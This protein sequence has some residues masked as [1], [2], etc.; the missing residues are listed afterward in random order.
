[1]GIE[2]GQ[3][4]EEMRAGKRILVVEDNLL[5]ADI[6]SFF[7]RDYG[8]EF[9][10]VDNGLTAVDMY[11]SS[12]YDLVLMDIML[13]GLNGY[14]ATQRIIENAGSGEKPLVI[15]VTAKV[16]RDNEQNSVM[17]GMVDLIHKPI[18]FNLLL[19]VLDKYLFGAET[20][21]PSI[22]PNRE[23][24]T[25]K[26]GIYDARMLNEYCIHVSESGA[27]REA[28]ISHFL[29]AVKMILLELRQAVEDGRDD[30]MGRLAHSLKGSL[31]L[32]GAWNMQDLARGFEAASLRR[33]ETFRPVHWLAVL[34]GAFAELKN[35]LVPRSAALKDGVV[36]DADNPF[37]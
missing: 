36:K 14:E 37:L 21:V 12:K 15:G 7:L 35:V 29:K 6:F 23:E 18:D 2:N 13:P 27:T 26:S 1:M 4:T 20:T 31:G 24:E 28:I 3:V 34:E 10:I 16:F 19:S 32:I 33:G 25:R 8:F 9:D 22:S 30:E 11:D 17:A 5:N